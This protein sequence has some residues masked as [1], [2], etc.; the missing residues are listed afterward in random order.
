MK[1]MIF[2]SCRVHGLS[3]D[4]HEIYKPFDLQH[5]IKHVNSNI[6][7]LKT[8]NIPHQPDVRRGISIKH[9]TNYCSKPDVIILEHCSHK[10]I[11]DKDNP[12]HIYNVNR[13][14]QLYDFYC[15]YKS[16]RQYY[17]LNLNAQIHYNSNNLKLKYF[18]HTPS[19]TYTKN[20]MYIEYNAGEMNNSTGF[21]PVVQFHRKHNTKVISFKLNISISINS[22]DH[23][24]K[25]YNGNKYVY[26][27]IKLSF[28]E[29]TVL[30]DI[31]NINT[32]KL[33]SLRIG[34]YTKSRENT[35]GLHICIHELD[36]SISSSTIRN[37][38]HL[39]LVE[40][41]QTY[42][43]LLLNTIEL[44]STFPESYIILVPHIIVYDSSQDLSYVNASR[45]HCKNILDK[46]CSMFHNVVLFDINTYMNTS[47]LEH[48]NGKIDINHY[49]E[50]GKN[51]ISG[52]LLQFLDFSLP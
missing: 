1:L 15:S 18:K 22:N 29:Q 48:K 32:G 30:I 12:E 21:F 34:V 27:D 4:N 38:N 23:Y 28:E 33:R 37:T 52:K 16:C 8:K 43:D 36:M 10:I 46:V 2:G 7:L 44:K 24:L 25:W 51:I 6:A 39:T 20:C 11:Y 3:Y 50:R 5:T 35:A 17:T 31:G 49:N 40:E 26:S 47:M 14:Q 41:K 19:E 9:N 45:T 42:N 13:I